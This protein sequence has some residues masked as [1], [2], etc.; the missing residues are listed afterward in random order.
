MNLEACLSNFRHGPPADMFAFGVILWELVT[1][2]L[3]IRGALREAKV[4]EEC[5][6][7]IRTL[8]DQCMAKDPA[9]RPTAKQVPTPSPNAAH[10]L[11]EII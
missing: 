1:Q 7:A 3:P 4:P 8:M 10:R 11:R 6:E 9:G 2:E 5:P